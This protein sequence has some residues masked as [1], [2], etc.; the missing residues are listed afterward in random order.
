M[1]GVLDGLAPAGGQEG[2]DIA[3]AVIRRLGD[4]PRE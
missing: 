4:P 1:L 2:P 3:T